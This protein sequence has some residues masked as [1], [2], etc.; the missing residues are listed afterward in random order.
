MGIINMMVE[1]YIDKNYKTIDELPAN[2]VVKLINKKIIENTK[3]LIIDDEKLEI[4]ETLRRIGYN[5]FWKKDIDILTE[6][7]DYQIII[8]DYKGVG[9]KFKSEFEGIYLL[10][11]IK[12]KYP[13][14]IVYL[15]SAASV[16][17]KVNNYIK[18]FNELIYKGDED[19]LIEYINQ[20]SQK[21]FNPRDMWLHYKTILK[22]KNISEKEIFQLENLYVQSFIDKK[23]RLTKNPLFKKIEANLNIDFDIKIGLINL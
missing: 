13:E 19:K 17:G 4:E 15:L 5:V 18:Y 21:F 10:H 7:E 9:L 8:C 12:E 1:K 22:G 14:K 3:I 20:D 2:A 6:V 23:D 11:L 16:N